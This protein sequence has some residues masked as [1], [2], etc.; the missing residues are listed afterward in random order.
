MH[1]VLSLGTF[2][3]L[4]VLYGWSSLETVMATTVATTLMY[5]IH[6]ADFIIYVTKTKIEVH[7]LDLSVVFPIN[8]D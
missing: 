6:K 2:L 3:F 5:F 8:L 4:E 1:S 7:A